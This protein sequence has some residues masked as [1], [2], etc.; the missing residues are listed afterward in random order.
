MHQSNS[1]FAARRAFPFVVTLVLFYAL[2]IGGKWFAITSP[3]FGS[4]SLVVFALSIGLWVWMQRGQPS[5]YQTPLNLAILLWVVAI[6]IASAANLDLWR[7]SAI[8]AWYVGSY[9]FAWYALQA[10]LAHRLITRQM[11]VSVLLAVIGV[12]VLF[13]LMQTSAALFGQPGSISPLRVLTTL[14]PGGL[15]I[16]P[17]WLSSFLVISL[18]FAIL[19]FA[20]TRRK[21]TRLL[22]G[23]LILL[24]GLVL[25]LTFSRGAWVAAA[26]GVVIPAMVVLYSR[27]QLNIRSLRHTWNSLSQWLRVGI[28]I[29]IVALA[30]AAIAFLATFTIGGRTVDYR[31]RLWEPAIHLFAEK[32]LTGY[33]LYSYGTGLLRFWSSPPNHMHS[34]AHN[35]ILNVAAELGIIG[36][37]ALA[38]TVLASLR[39]MRCNWTT[40]PRQRPF[41]LATLGA[42]TAFGVQQL[43]DVTILLPSIA[44]V[45]LVALALATAPFDPLPASQRQ[46]RLQ[47][48]VILCTALA[49]LMTGV[50]N[51]QQQRASATIIDNAGR[52]V[53]L[54]TSAA[55]LQTVIDSDPWQAA[56]YG[57]QAM[58]LGSAAADDASQVDSSIRAYE[59]FVALEPTYPPAWA[60]LGALYREAGQTTQ[61][62][63]AMSSAAMLAPNAAALSYWQGRYLE[64]AGNADDAEASYRNALRLM[65]L[66]ADTELWNVT[67]VQAQMNISKPLIDETRVADWENALA[68]FTRIF[69]RSRRV[70]VWLQDWETAFLLQYLQPALPRQFL[71]QVGYF[72]NVGY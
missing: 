36:L 23:I 19:Q 51:N 3:D 54:T 9:I 34:H 6:I 4:L 33:G 67:P 52:S 71:P 27:N 55:A 30:V 8:G 50:W 16:N 5:R 15:F 31:T 46:R 69:E 2:V 37:A 65:P 24:G 70:D 44:L 1:V 40:T 7:R 43:F 17:N 20:T 41:I 48:P 21:P 45:G 56:N 11:M 39:A 68:S 13:A 22:T 42:I 26:A 64:E 25:L 18:P 63:E 47:T 61:A 32:P 60:N 57:Q 72:P 66:L 10:G 62:A 49:L 53:D 14:R 38:A 35:L 12:E 28:I 58:L 59:Q 29:G